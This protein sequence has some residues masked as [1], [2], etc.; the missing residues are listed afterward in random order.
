MAPRRRAP[1]DSVT[2]AGLPTG[3]RSERNAHPLVDSK[4]RIALIHNGI[5]EN[6]LE[7]KHRLVDDGWSF[8]SDTDTEVIANLISS[9]PRR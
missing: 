8:V 7:I 5:V 2:P 3:R 6:F 9:H 4:G 1:L